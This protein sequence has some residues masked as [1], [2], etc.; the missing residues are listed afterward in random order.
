MSSCISKDDM[1]VIGPLIHYIILYVS[2]IHS[3]VFVL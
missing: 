3:L 2:T 1:A